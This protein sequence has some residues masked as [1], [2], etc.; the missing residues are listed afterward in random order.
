MECPINVFSNII[1]LTIMG[2][3]FDGISF[4]KTDLYDIEKRF[5]FTLDVYIPVVDPITNALNPKFSDMIIFEKSIAKGK[6]VK[7]GYIIYRNVDIKIEAEN[8]H[9]C[10]KITQKVLNEINLQLFHIAHKKESNA[11]QVS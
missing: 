4:W 10:L 9:E 1:D 2:K 7:I 3:F 5:V 8:F 11:E 6:L